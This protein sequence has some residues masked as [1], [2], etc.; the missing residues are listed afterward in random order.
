MFTASEQ[1]EGSGVQV[2]D[3]KP[4]EGITGRTAQWPRTTQAHHAFYKL[5]SHKAFLNAISVQPI[6]AQGT[7]ESVM[8][9][10]WFMSVHMGLLQ[11]YWSKVLYWVHSYAVEWMHIVVTNNVT[12]YCQMCLIHLK[13]TARSLLPTSLKLYL[14]QIPA[15][16]KCRKLSFIPILLNSPYQNGL[17][18]QQHKAWSRLIP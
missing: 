8:A 11:P 6:W 7:A 2:H 5:Q 1:S 12:F 16:L 9:I 13:W 15:W 10:Q 4:L 3:G 17:G 18:K 14:I